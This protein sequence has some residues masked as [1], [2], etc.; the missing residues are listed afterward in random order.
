MT[1]KAMLKNNIQ[2]LQASGG[3][4]ENAELFQQGFVVLRNNSS[5][6]EV[7]KVLELIRQGQNQ[8][9]SE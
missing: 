2:S 7:V 5:Q 8:G 1:V 3:V 6:R 4:L 9:G